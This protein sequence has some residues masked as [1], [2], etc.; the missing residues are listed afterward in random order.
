MAQAMDKNRLRTAILA[1]IPRELPPTPVYDM[2]AIHAPARPNTLTTKEKKQA[3]KNA[4]RYFP[5]EW[6]AILASEFATELRVFGRIYMYRFKPAYPIMAYPIDWYPGN[7]LAARALQLMYMNNL[8]PQNAQYP[9]ELVTYGGTGT[10]FQN[11]VQ[12]LITMQ[13][14]A[15]LDRDQML[16][17]YS[18]HPLG[19]FPARRGFDPIAVIVNGLMSAPL[20]ADYDNLAAK[21]VTLY[22]Q[23]TAGSAMYI[24]SQGIVH[25]TY[26][27]LLNAF[28]EYYRITDMKDLRG[29]VFVSSGLGGMSGAQ[30]KAAQIL[31]IVC[32]IAEVNLKAIKKRIEK[33][34]ID[35]YSDS[36]DA[37]IFA[38]KSAIAEKQPLSIA[39]HG[40]IVD[41]WNR[42]ITEDIQV[43]LASDQTSL[44]LPFAGGYFPFQ[45][46][47]E[48]ALQMIKSDAGR[49]TE[50][51]RESLREHVRAINAMA[52][53]GTKFFDYGNGFLLQARNAGADIMADDTRFRYPSYVEDLMGPICF[54]FGFGPFRW[55]CLSGDPKD[56]EKT[57]EIAADVIRE[58][59]VRAPLQIRQQY[60]D[61]LYWIENA[62]KYGLVVGSQ[63]RILYSDRV[64]RTRIALAFNR[65]VASGEIG[66]VVIGRDHHDVG[67]TDSKYRETSNVLDGSNVC[68]DMSV[69][70]FIG[71]ATAHADWVSIHNGG[72]VGFNYAINGGFGIALD[73]SVEVAER[74]KRLMAI[75]V[76]NGLARRAWAGNPNAIWAI[77]ESMDDDARL[78]VMIPFIADD[79]V[80]SKAV[81]AS[82]A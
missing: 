70:N 26:I 7:T 74:I 2:N 62:G 29:R 54:D 76:N 37:I 22:G 21:G 77:T 56:L 75:D 57:D 1:G 49:F 5:K 78:Q 51:V 64:G 19:K 55:V 44:N 24:G 23:M 15:T 79:D 4:L 38:M 66:P 30:G 69:Q 65:A 18:G 35:S 11:W 40:N 42:L 48:D 59:L 28:R 47:F 60:E 34:W 13:A 12:Y 16:K 73:G 27:T 6:H 67:G 63:A 14:L 39:Y 25:G 46:S 72:G 68:A 80:V 3:V 82:I 45:I 81:D 36:L 61:N 58:L 20:E 52:E 43:D 10:V 9:D 8:D 53:R 41:L 17:L 32:V 33:G 71:D 50:L 31:G